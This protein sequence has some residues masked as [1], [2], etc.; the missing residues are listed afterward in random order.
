VDPAFWSTQ[1]ST[2]RP[3]PTNFLNYVKCR[4]GWY[5]PPTKHYPSKFG[6]P[7]FFF[8]GGQFFFRFSLPDGGRS[9]TKKICLD[10]P[11][12]LSPKRLKHYILC[13][14]SPPSIPLPFRSAFNL[15]DSLSLSPLNT[16][17][18]LNGSP[19]LS[20][21]PA[22][23]YSSSNPCSAGSY[24]RRSP[25][26]PHRLFPFPLSLSGTGPLNLFFVLSV[27]LADTCPLPSPKSLSVVPPPPSPFHPSD[28]A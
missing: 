2:P 28:P 19:S 10:G 16:K 25:V 15:W 8:S 17:V 20:I 13:S 22:F 24:E 7:S 1:R 23:W 12:F 3:S 4:R 27:F 11:Y 26:Q 9:Y 5:F 21:C 14:P 18:K 6:P